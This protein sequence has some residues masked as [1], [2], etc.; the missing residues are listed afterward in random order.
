MTPALAAAVASGAAAAAVA[1]GTPGSLQVEEEDPE[2]LFPQ[3][4]SGSRGA[5]T[6]SPLGLF[7][8]PL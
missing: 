7:H 8:H 1:S 5:S 4:R 2:P 3:V 6:V